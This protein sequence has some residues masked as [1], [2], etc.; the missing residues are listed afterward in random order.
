VGWIARLFIREMEEKMIKELRSAYMRRL[1]VSCLALES[2]S[3]MGL[4]TAK[5]AKPTVK[6]MRGGQTQ[7]EAKEQTLVAVV[8]RLRPDLLRTDFSNAH[9]LIPHR[10]LL[11]V[12][13]DG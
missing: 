3:N 9:F 12:S 5:T 11:V 13:H 7:E 10:T 1:P 6:L 8:R 2:P 4:S